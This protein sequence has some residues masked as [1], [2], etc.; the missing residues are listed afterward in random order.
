MCGLDSIMQRDGG[1]PAQLLLD[2]SVVGV[3]AAHPLWSRYVL[4]R[5]A[6]AL[7]THG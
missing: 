2:H 4:D 1:R 6:L 7:E 3:A 5:E